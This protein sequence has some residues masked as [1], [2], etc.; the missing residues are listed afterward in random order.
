LQLWRGAALADVAQ[1]PFAEPEV[2]R[3][4]EL[5]L[6]ATER[7][8]DAG[9]ECGRHRELVAEVDGLVTQYP[10]RERFWAQLMLALYRC[11]RQAD[12]LAAFQRARDR[13][14]GELGIEPGIQ[15]R[16]LEAAILAQDGSLDV[17]GADRSV[18]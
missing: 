11:G 6:V 8:I 15:L 2:A 18:G 7:R 14:V 1:F 10:L 16:A 5:R 13:L 4:E 9:L 3:L 17:N 12:A